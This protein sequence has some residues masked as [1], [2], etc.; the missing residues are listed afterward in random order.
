MF[1]GREES[2][3]PAV[4]EKRHS[5]ATTHWSVVLA[6]RDS[7]PDRARQALERICATYWYPIYVCIRRSGKTHDQAEDLTQ[8]FF[9][10]LLSHQAFQ[11]LEPNKGRVRSYLWVALDR[12]LCREEVAHTVGDPK[13]VE[14]ELN[15]LVRVFGA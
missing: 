14:D 11:R 15:H 13:E 1:P 10:R 8:G 7:E 5:F 6:T 12:Y 9:Q 3:S 4:P 2:A